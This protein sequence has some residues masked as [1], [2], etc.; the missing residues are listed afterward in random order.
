LLNSTAVLRDGKKLSLPELIKE[1]PDLVKELAGGRTDIQKL[2]R[3][4]GLIGELEDPNLLTVAVR[5][6]PP[7]NPEGPIS[8]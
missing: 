5:K 3:L 1:L 8:P 2:L 6:T 4:Y 7:M